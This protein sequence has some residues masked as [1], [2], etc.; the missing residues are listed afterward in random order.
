MKKYQIY[1]DRCGKEIK[2][3]MRGFSIVWLNEEGIPTGEPKDLC[4]ECQWSLKNWLFKFSLQWQNFL[5]NHS[6]FETEEINE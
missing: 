6:Y 4:K 5:G 3:S 1:C 2:L